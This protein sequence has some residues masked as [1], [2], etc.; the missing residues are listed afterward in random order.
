[1]LILKKIVTSFEVDEGYNFFFLIF[2][3]KITLKDYELHVLFWTKIDQTR[4]L[5]DK[6]LQFRI[7]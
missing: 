4:E 2:C 6:K 5:I 7:S 3:C 1:M